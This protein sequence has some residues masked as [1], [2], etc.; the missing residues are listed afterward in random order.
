MC[1]VAAAANA[2]PDALPWESCVTPRVAKVTDLLRAMGQGASDAPARVT[3]WNRLL[4]AEDQPT[5][6]KLPLASGRHPWVGTRRSLRKVNS[7]AMLKRSRKRTG[8]VKL[9]P[10]APDGQKIQAQYWCN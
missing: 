10:E 5:L 7:I 2:V 3:A 8:V 1:S 4:L 6:N 9:L